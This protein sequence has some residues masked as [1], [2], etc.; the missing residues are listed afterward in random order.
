[1]REAHTKVDPRLADSAAGER[2]RVA[3][4]LPKETRRAL[5]QQLHAGA[6]PDEAKARVSIPEQVVDQ[7]VAR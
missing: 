7:E 1:V 3:C 6:S 5:W 4:L 2:H